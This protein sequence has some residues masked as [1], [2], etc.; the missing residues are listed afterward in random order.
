VTLT[1][2]T[3]PGLLNGTVTV[4]A[5]GGVATFTDL[6]VTTAGNYT[7]LATDGSLAS[8]TT[9]SFSVTPAAASRL[10]FVQQPG[11]AAM[12]ASL[13]PAVVVAVEDQYGNLVTSE[14]SNVTISVARGPLAVLDGTLTEPAVNGFATF[15][16]LSLNAGGNFQLAATDG[17][18]TAD[19]ES[20]AVAVEPAPVGSTASHLAFVQEPQTLTA[21]VATASAFVI[22]VEDQAG[23]FVTSG[24]SRV[25]L[26]ILSG[27]RGSALHGTATVL[28]QGGVATFS[29]VDL[30]VAGDYTFQVKDGRLTTAVS[31]TVLVEPSAPV[32]LLYIHQPGNAIAGN[33]IDAPVV[34][35]LKDR[36]NNIATNAD[37]V[38]TLSIASGPAGAVVGGDASVTADNGLATFS[39]VLLD[40]AGHYRLTA[41]DGGLTVKSQS[42]AIAPAAAAALTFEQQSADAVAGHAPA[43]PIK[44]SVTDAFGN[45]VANGT[46]VTLALASAPD[47]G[48][49]NGRTTAVTHNGIAEF[50]GVTFPTAGEYTL[51]ATAGSAVA[52]SAPI[53]VSPA[54]ASRLVFLQAPANVTTNT[55]FSVKIELLDRYGNVVTN[56]SSVVTVTLGSHPAQAVLSGPYRSPV[57][58]G[59]ATFSGLTLDSIGTYTLRFEDESLHLISPSFDVI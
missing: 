18:I 32:K 57:T 51:A 47:F 22:D 5:D 49:I 42:I 19:S 45:A 23:E 30:T 8:A 37:A 1:V 26:S 11:N 15:S 33:A 20:F 55:A 34:V 9:G 27:P 2:N 44:I 36:F 46:T 14:S 29:N 28:S 6:S 52:R 7:L 17:A 41:S 25:T 24:T 31:D 21:G 13:S 10:V 12:D 53:T 16:D 54:V 4:Q 40:T 35:E 48:T 58:D 59:V 38:V 50:A 43:L 39:D 56:N 3:G